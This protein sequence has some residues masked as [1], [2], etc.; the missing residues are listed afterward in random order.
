MIFIGS[1]RAFANTETPVDSSPSS[2]NFARSCLALSSDNP[3]PGT[4]PSSTAALVAERASSTLF[5]FS[6]SSISVAAPTLIMATPPDNLANL[7][8]NFSLSKSDVVSSICA[9][10]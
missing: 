5:F 4:I 9:F 3:P 8:C 10:I 1:S 2:F 6:F 7:S